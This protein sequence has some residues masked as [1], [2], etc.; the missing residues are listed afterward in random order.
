M[1]LGG[2]KVL[3]HAAALS[4][5]FRWGFAKTPTAGVL[6]GLEVWR[7]RYLGGTL[8]IVGTVLFKSFAERLDGKQHVYRSNKTPER[9]TLLLAAL[10][11]VVVANDLFPC[12]SR[13]PYLIFDYQLLNLT[14]VDAGRW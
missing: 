5:V 6:F 8:L 3:R 10:F 13:H 12:R 1:A 2:S 9:L 11:F 14:L 4:G 7:R